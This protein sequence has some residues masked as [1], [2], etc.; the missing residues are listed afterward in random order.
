LSR[1][2][3]KKTLK[4]S[5]RWIQALVNEHPQVLNASVGI[6]DITWLS[7][8]A[9]DKYAEY[10]DAAFLE[11]LDLGSLRPALESFWPAGGPQWD[12]LGRAQTGEVILLEAKAHVPEMLSPPSQ[13]VDESLTLIRKSLLETS[14]ALGT[15]P[16]LDWSIRFYQYTNRLAHAHFLQNLNGIR[17]RLVFL[18]IIGDEEVNGPQNRAEW[19]AA[20]AVLNEALGLRGKRLR[21]K[22]DAFIDIRGPSPIVA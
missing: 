10:R 4:G 7:P 3:Q 11:R 9:S 14:I 22:V 19:E 16:G 8:L 17:T 2:P 6:T 12:A 15:A 18:Y 13:A 5:Q 20:L 1:V 21:F